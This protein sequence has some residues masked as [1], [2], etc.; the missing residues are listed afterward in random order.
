[1]GAMLECLGSSHWKRECITLAQVV[2]PMHGVSHTAE[3]FILGIQKPAAWGM[4]EWSTYAA[5]CNA[6]SSDA[7]GHNCTE[8]S[9]DM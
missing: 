4:W 3:L 8:I 7:A 5:L 1:M 2:A 9:G 6:F